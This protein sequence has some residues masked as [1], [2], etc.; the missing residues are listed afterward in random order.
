[1]SFGDHILC[2]LITRLPP[3]ARTMLW[4]YF[5][6]TSPSR[7]SSQPLDHLS[8]KSPTSSFP[9]PYGKRSPIDQ[10]LHYQQTDPVNE[11]RAAHT[12]YTA[13]LQEPL[14]ATTTT[15]VLHS[16]RVSTA[17][18]VHAALSGFHQRRIQG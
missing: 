4:K 12:Y 13:H 16:A 6:S 3:H 1:M 7:R 18:Q 2:D 14:A 15:I 17:L 11:S 9:R 10:L 8:Q 5:K